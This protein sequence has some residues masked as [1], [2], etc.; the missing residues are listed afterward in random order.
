M[1]AA[2]IGPAHFN[3]LANYRSVPGNQQ[4]LR[5]AWFTVKYT[6]ITTIVLT[7]LAF[8]LALLVQQRRRGA[9][10]LRTA[11]FLPAMIGLAIASLLW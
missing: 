7:A 3:G 4:F 8:G 2:L 9:G 5:S 6:V 11:Y 10:A 1:R